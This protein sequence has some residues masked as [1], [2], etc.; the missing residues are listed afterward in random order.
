MKPKKVKKKYLKLARK[1][2]NDLYK[3]EDL[4]QYLAELLEQI[5]E[6]KSHIKFI[7][8]NEVDLTK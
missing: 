8:G 6:L 7:T 3:D 5:A 1:D 4:I 2:F